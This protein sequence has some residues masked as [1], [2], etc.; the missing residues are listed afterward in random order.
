M[1]SQEKH[2]NRNQYNIIPR[3]LKKQ[4]GNLYLD[5]NKNQW[6]LNE[7]YYA[8]YH[9]PNHLYIS[10][11]RSIVSKYFF[12]LFKVPNLKFIRKTYQDKGISEVVVNRY[13][14]TLI[15]D[16][17]IFGTFNFCHASDYEEDVMSN[18]NLPSSGLHKT[19]DIDP[20]EKYGANY[21][22]IGILDDKILTAED[23]INL[24]ILQETD[25]I[26]R[27]YL[28]NSVFILSISSLLYLIKYRKR[29]HFKS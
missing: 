26:L 12:G 17:L 27:T 9:Q 29:R 7:D 4:K 19:R 11:L 5:E 20:H 22:H 18:G 14:G 24:T 6:V 28:I 21:K 1:I 25:N 16:P 23:N 15:T 3:I 13:N 2:E 10:A 8:S